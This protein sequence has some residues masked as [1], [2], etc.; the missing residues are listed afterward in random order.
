MRLYARTSMFI[1]F[2]IFWKLSVH[3]QSC[4]PLTIVCPADITVTADPGSCGEIVNY[5]ILTDGTCPLL[6]LAQIDQSGLTS[7]DEFPIGT[8]VQ[9]WRSEDS[10]GFADTCT[11]LIHILEFPNPIHAGACNANVNISP[12]EDCEVLVTADMILEGGPYG[13]YDNYMVVITTTNGDPVPN[14]LTSDYVGETLIAMV[15]DSNGN[16]CWGYLHYEDYLITPLECRSITINCTDDYLPST[17]P[18]DSIPFPVPGGYVITPGSGHGPFIVEDYDNCGDISLSFTDQVVEIDC[19]LGGPYTRQ[20]FRT[21]TAEDEQGNTTTCIDTINLRIPDFSSSTVFPDRNGTDAP[22]ILCSDDWDTNGDGIPQPEE[23]GDILNMNCDLWGEYTDIIHYLNCGVLIDRSWEIVNMCTGEFIS[24]IQQIRLEDD[25][26]PIIVCDQDLTGSTSLIDCHSTYHVHAPY[27]EDDCSSVTYTVS[28]SAGQVINIGTPQDPVYIIEGLPVGTYTI[29]FTAIDGCGNESSCTSTLEILDLVPP[30]ANCENHLTVYLGSGQ[31]GVDV[32]DLDIYSRDGCG[33]AEMKLRRVLQGECDGT[34]WDDLQWHDFETFCCEEAGQTILI[35]LGVWDIY[36]NFSSCI[37]HVSV[38]SNTAP[39]LTCPPDITISCS[40]PWDTSDL[41][42]FGTIV[43]HPDDI[44]DIYIDDPDWKTYCKGQPYT[45]PMLWGQDGLVT[46]EC[47]FDIIETT[48]YNLECGRSVNENGEYLPAIIRTFDVGNNGGT[49]NSCQQKIYI[50][51]CNPGTSAIEWPEDVVLDACLDESTNPEDTGW[52]TL[53]PGSCDELDSEYMDAEQPVNGDTCRH[54]LRSWTVTSAC[55]SGNDSI[56][57]TWDQNI[58]VIRTDTIQLINCTDSILPDSAFEC[59]YNPENGC[60]VRFEIIPPG[61]VFCDS[62]IG[63]T[64]EIDFNVDSTGVFNPDTS[65]AGELPEY[66]P[67]G[68]HQIRWSAMDMCGDMESCTTVVYVPDCEPPMAMCED[69]GVQVIQD[70]NGIVIYASDITGMSMDNCGSITSYFLK[71]DSSMSLNPKLYGILDSNLVEI[72]D[73]SGKILNSTKLSDM[74]GA[75]LGA[76]EYIPSKGK[77]Y[78]ILKGDGNIPG[79]PELVSIDLDGTVAG[80]GIF[81]GQGDTLRTVEG[82]V[83]IPERDALMVSG[84]FDDMT[85]VSW[86]IF[87]VDLNTAAL[88]SGFFQLGPPLIVD[89]DH[90]AWY[91]GQLWTNFHADSIFNRFYTIDLP[92]TGSIVSAE[93]QFDL[94]SNLEFSDFA[95]YGNW[96]YAQVDNDLVRVDLETGALEEIGETHDPLDFHGNNISGLAIVQPASI[97]C[98][99]EESCEINCTDLETIQD[100]FEYTI[101]VFDDFG[102][103]DTCSGSFIVA[104]SNDLCEEPQCELIY[105]INTSGQYYSINTA[106]GDFSLIVDANIPTN[107]NAVAVNDA[108]GIGYFGTEQSFYWV[109]LVTGDYGLVGTISVPGSLSA[110]AASCWNGYLYFGPESANQVNDIY[111]IE[112]SSDG[113][114]FVVPVPD[115]LTN[116]AVPTGNFGDFVVLEG[117]VG[118]ERMVMSIF[119]NI[120][121]NI[122][123]EYLTDLNTFTQLSVIPST[124][125]S[126][127][128]IDNVGNIWYFNNATGT[129][130]QVDIF[131]GQVTN[132]NPVAVTISDMGRAWCP[133]S[134]VS[135]VSDYN[136]FDNEWNAFIYPNP[137]VFVPTLEFTLPSSEKLVFKLFSLN[138]E[139][140]YSQ[141]INGASGVNELQLNAGLVP[142][143]YIYRLEGESGLVTGKYIQLK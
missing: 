45:G 122:I 119:N 29:E 98:V 74:Y 86:R 97:D 78:S 106:T 18:L 103:S 105:A 41:S 133:P 115:N 135:G 44:S 109:D 16:S 140:I 20:I 136:N 47:D 50:L 56:L 66:L 39:S 129:L 51:E 30:E 57:G 14:P 81:T 33:I 28:S 23:I 64:W 21:W 130:G 92:D 70:T 58:Y 1:A 139:L 116:G 59:I 7:G 83:Y 63:L 111:R 53:A 127:I 114:S 17:D 79:Y 10:T 37:T 142:A 104:D 112:L 82:L 46:S 24:F 137:S 13:C 75:D 123:W 62:S 69:I 42:V 89:I 11:F 40:F 27:I 3:G 93:Y 143:T 8:T 48:T 84:S 108:L 34:S 117:D 9:T 19:T 76:L 134:M 120:N 38:E 85:S 95:A 4:V 99:L 71:C 2:I 87:E 138:G 65:G 52:P 110:A 141:D 100:T 118:E 32:E 31:D 125:S 55:A 96:L 25:E 132:E 43:T 60:E 121:A 113:K 72:D 54:I 101:V 61:V 36:G 107:T 124:S 126:Q 128:T 90:M 77:F 35:E 67:V 80:I 131:T 6:S 49:I 94:D 26:P 5:T 22:S 88:K 73:E 12:D 102:N 68:W 15:L 91:D